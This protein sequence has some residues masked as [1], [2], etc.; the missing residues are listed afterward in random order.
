MSIVLSKPLIRVQTLRQVLLPTDGSKKKVDLLTPSLPSRRSSRLQKVAP[1]N[2]TEVHG[3]KSNDDLTESDV[4]LIGEGRERSCTLKRMRNC[5]V[6][7]RRHGPCL[8]MDMVRITSAFMTRSKG[9][10][11]TNVDMVKMF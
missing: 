11:V 9:K 8:W 4:A 1:V 3:K 2:Y 10:H 6:H 5:L 7:V